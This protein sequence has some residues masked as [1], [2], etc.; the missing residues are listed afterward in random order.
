MVG[1]LDTRLY[2]QQVDRVHEVL[3]ERYPSLING[4]RAYLQHYSAVP[5]R[6]KL[7]KA[8]LEELNGLEVL[9][10]PAYSPRGTI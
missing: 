5:H 7:T 2:S 9:P 6:A 1:S 10:R 4:K 8:K 3:R